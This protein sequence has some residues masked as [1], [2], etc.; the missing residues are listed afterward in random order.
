MTKYD[1]FLRKLYTNPKYTSSFSSVEKL[2]K[3]AKERYASITRKHVLEFLSGEK[4]YTKH[5]PIIRKF[6]RRRYI[7]PKSGSTCLMDVAYML[8]YS[9]NNL[10]Y[11][12]FLMD[13][14]SRYLSV[15]PLKS[16]KT[17]DVLPLVKSFFEE[18]LYTYTHVLSDKGVEFTSKPM[19][20]LYTKLNLKWYSV[21]SEKKVAPIERVIKTI[22]LRIYKYLTYS[23]GEKYSSI[24]T[25]LVDSYNLSPHRG[26]LGESPLDVHLMFQ[27]DEILSFTQR[28]NRFHS[29]KNKSVGFILSPETVVRLTSS[30]RVFMRSFF[31]QATDELFRVKTV[32]RH[33]TPITYTIE[34]LDGGKVEGI[35]YRRELVP[36]KDSGHY[37]IKILKTR[38]KN[39]IKQYYVRY[40]DFPMSKP[41][42]VGAKQL[43]KI[44]K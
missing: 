12:L 6:P 14:F 11:L 43:Q 7:F 25:D 10:P 21:N 4:S 13:G 22:K 27:D 38:I 28:I 9:K 34:D 8:D 24:L 3:A 23:R 30:D 41:S 37:D 35:F 15:I 40:I 19:K 33:H 17:S 36:V 18:N 26:L 31:T 1:K 16:L 29:D 44:T 2:L 32:N 39:R 5:V 42:W 20:N